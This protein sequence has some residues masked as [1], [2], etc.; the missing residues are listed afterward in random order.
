MLKLLLMTIYQINH[1][2]LDL[3]A[4]L[5]DL[6]RPVGTRSIILGIFIPFI[7]QYMASHWLSCMISDQN[8]LY[9]NF[10]CFELPRKMDIWSIQRQVL[11]WWPVFLVGVVRTATARSCYYY[12]LVRRLVHG[13]GFSWDL[14]QDLE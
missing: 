5:K 2:F 13:L 9:L 14:P 7:L 10:M 4:N 6:L 8:I 3:L 11:P 1:I 12:Y